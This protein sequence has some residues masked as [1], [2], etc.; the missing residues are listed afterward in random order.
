M[1]LMVGVLPAICF[2]QVGHLT[3]PIRFLTAMVGEFMILEAEE[4]LWRFFVRVEPSLGEELER[5]NWGEKLP[6]KRRDSLLSL[7]SSS[8]RSVVSSGT[9]SLRRR[10]GRKVDRRAGALEIRQRELGVVRERRRGVDSD[11]RSWCR[12]EVS[13]SVGGMS[14]DIGSSVS[15]RPSPGPSAPCEV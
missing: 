10:G 11:G 8:Q 7:L 1:S 5:W 14:T 9:V 4:L 15:I 13:S 2:R 6:E 3:L 12:R